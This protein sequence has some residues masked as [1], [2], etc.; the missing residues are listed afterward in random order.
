MVWDEKGLL[1]VCTE[2]M[3]SEGANCCAT[4][5]AGNILEQQRPKGFVVLKYK[6]SMEGIQSN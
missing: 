6:G 5:L 2:R 4:I 1:I 3:V